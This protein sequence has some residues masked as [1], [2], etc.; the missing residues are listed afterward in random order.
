MGNTE[1]HIHK[2]LIDKC[3]KGDQKAQFEI[4]R[5]YYKAMFNTC[6]RIVND[7]A[8]AEDLMQEAFLGAFEKLDSYNANASFGAWL[9]RIVVN[10]A[11]DSLK[12]KKLLLDKLD[13]YP[14]IINDEDFD[15]EKG[16]SKSVEQIK[17]AILQLPDGYRIVLSLY[18]LEGYDH[19]EIAEILNI[20]A[21]GSRSQLTRAKKKLQN[22]LEN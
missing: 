20:T 14:H 13:D 6:L 8:E 12:K 15:I 5:L 19:D 22:L 7:R 21:S 11:L 18:L 2:L 3:R 4:Y 16:K 1:Y 10:K 9:K 17:K